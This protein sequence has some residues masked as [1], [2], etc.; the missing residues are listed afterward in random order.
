[1]RGVGAGTVVLAAAAGFLVGVWSAGLLDPR[2]RPRPT[3]LGVVVAALFAAVVARLGLVWS[4]PA[5]GQPVTLRPRAADR[6]RQQNARRNLRTRY[7]TPGNWLVGGPPPVPCRRSVPFD[8]VL[9]AADEYHPRPT[10]TS[11][12]VI[13]GA[14]G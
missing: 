2:I 9:A 11:R 3:L 12:S 5:A 14:R 6:H 7:R 13:V 1:V 10:G 4:L 8:V